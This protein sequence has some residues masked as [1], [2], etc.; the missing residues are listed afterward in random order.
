M[1]HKKRSTTAKQLSSFL[2]WHYIISNARS[3]AIFVSHIL[4]YMFYTRWSCTNWCSL[5]HIA[6]SA[7]NNY[8]CLLISW[9][10]AGFSPKQHDIIQTGYPTGIRA[11]GC[12]RTCFSQPIAENRARIDFL[13]WGTFMN[14]E[15]QEVGSPVP[16]TSVGIKWIF[17]VGY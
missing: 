17:P 7:R 1:K 9:L 3:N 2:P 15:A 5:F 16:S 13:T 11:A 12:K 6:P 14:L 4:S 8:I 10:S